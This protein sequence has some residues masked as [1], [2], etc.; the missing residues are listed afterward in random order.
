MTENIRQFYMQ[1]HPTILL[2]NCQ[3]HQKQGQSKKLS[4]RKPENYKYMV[5]WMGSKNRI[6]TL[7]K[8]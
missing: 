6:R 2:K 1:E 5:S 3:G 4:L 8:N 7:G